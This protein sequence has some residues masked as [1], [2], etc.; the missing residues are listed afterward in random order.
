MPDRLGDPPLSVYFV[1]PASDSD[2]RLSS[3]ILQFRLTRR[4]FGLAAYL[5]L[6][7]LIWPFSEARLCWEA[8]LGELPCTRAEFGIEA[9]LLKYVQS[10]RWSH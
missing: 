9:L 10:P 1:F 7:I 4:L 2:L 6:F 8:G 3:S 5:L